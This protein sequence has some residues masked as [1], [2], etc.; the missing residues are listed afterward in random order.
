MKAIQLILTFFTILVIACGGPK[1]TI[2]PM[3]KKVSH[4]VAV[5]NF[6]SSGFLSSQKLGKFTADELAKQLFLKNRA[7][8]IDRG[9]VNAAV[10]H[11]GIASGNFLTQKQ[12]KKLAKTLQ[13]QIIILGEVRNIA[14]NLGS[15]S[16]KNTYLIITYRLLDPESGTVLAIIS[17]EKKS[18]DEVEKLIK[19]MIKDMV[20][21]MGAFK[22]RD[23]KK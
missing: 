1:A 19:D 14:R 4:R 12:L 2:A 21:S 18:S 15:L 6:T 20:D 23:G 10:A 9:I 7:F 3:L 5:L 13:T 22:I 8:V 17:H 16:Q 11:N